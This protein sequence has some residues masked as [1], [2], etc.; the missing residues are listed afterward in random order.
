MQM[1]WGR[2]VSDLA[3]SEFVNILSY[4]TKVK[5]IDRFYPS[6]KTC[7]SCGVLNH[8]INNNLEQLKNRVF[9]CDSCGLILDKDYNASLNIQ[10]VGAS[11]LSIE[12]VRPT[13]VG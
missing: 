2:K 6:S 9:I 13:L 5:K 12:N 10:R 1:M 4:K 3:F 11:T 7:S 8:K